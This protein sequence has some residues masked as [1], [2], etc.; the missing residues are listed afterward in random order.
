MSRENRLGEILRRREERER[1]GG[2]LT[3]QD[4]PTPRD[5]L[6]LEEGKAKTSP[7][8]SLSGIKRRERAKTSRTKGKG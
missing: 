4:S 2:H 3:A 6:V 7:F 8:S 1:M 5:F